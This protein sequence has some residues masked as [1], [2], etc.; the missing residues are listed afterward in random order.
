MSN[1]LKVLLGKLF[2]Y[3]EFKR[4]SKIPRYFQ[5]DTTIL[6]NIIKFVDSAS[7]L[8]LYKE[9]FRQEIYKFNTDTLKP[10]IIDCGAN[11]GLSII[12]FKR[13]Y[14]ESEIIGFEPDKRI[15]DI[16][17]FNISSFNLE[18]ITLINKGLWNEETTLK[19]FSEGA[20]GG[21]I[22]VE[23]DKKNIVEIQ[24]V[25]LREYLSKTVDFL[26]IDIEGAE[27]EVLKDCKDLLN[28]VKHIFVEYHSFLN[29]PQ[30][31]DIICKILKDAGF[32]YYIQHIGVIATYPL[33]H[34]NSYLGMDNQLNI[35][36]YR[37]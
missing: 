8:F 7:F 5:S 31:L 19:F 36:G 25:R 15:F 16:L 3:F 1:I 28:N 29:K 24:T 9:I 22:A 2:N 30:E 35:F 11:I 20:D 37:S 14:P 10:S 13:L 21:R 4:I 23:G 33:C 27:V 18:N 26:K 12:Y 6:G 17:T 32:R 34:I